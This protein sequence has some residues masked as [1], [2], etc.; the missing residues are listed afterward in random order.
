MPK[1][2]DAII[3]LTVHACRGTWVLLR[4]LS[5]VLCPSHD[6]QSRRVVPASTEYFQQ[7]VSSSDRNA[8]HPSATPSECFSSESSMG[9]GRTRYIAELTLPPR[10][11]SKR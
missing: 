10:F 4:W 8:L 6:D 9:G 2:R 3:E 5:M 7:L 1:A 11:T